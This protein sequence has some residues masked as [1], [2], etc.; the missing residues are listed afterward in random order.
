MTP[1]VIEP[2]IFPEEANEG[3]SP[4]KRAR[5]DRI[6]ESVM[7]KFDTPLVKRKVSRLSS[8]VSLDG[9][10]ACTPQSILKVCIVTVV[11]Y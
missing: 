6:S 9:I 3:A 7:K 11:F 4:P 5:L 1:T 8:R 10:N 2:S